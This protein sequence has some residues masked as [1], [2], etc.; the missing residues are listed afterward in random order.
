MV[1]CVC[2]QEEKEARW[3][4][5]G[6]RTA[7]RPPRMTSQSIEHRVEAREGA[8]DRGRGSARERQSRPEAEDSAA[9][10]GEERPGRPVCRCRVQPQRR[11]RQGLG[12]P[13]VTRR[14]DAPSEQGRP[15][16]RRGG[17]RLGTSWH[18]VV[19]VPRAEPGKPSA[20]PAASARV[21]RTVCTSRLP[22]T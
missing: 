2:T 22:C 11:M 9:G 7:R 8:G 12:W 3:G 4:Q 14:E 21:T 10:G 19:A 6:R 1:S 13:P 20:P 5:E 18:K 15:L 17:Q 16:C